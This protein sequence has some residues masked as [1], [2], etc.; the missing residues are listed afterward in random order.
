MQTLG[1]LIFPGFEL[2][3]LFGP[4]EMFRLMK[5]DFDLKLVGI[6]AGAIPSNGQVSAYAGCTIADT[7]DFD[8]ILIP[9]GS[10]TRKIVDDPTLMAW[11]RAASDQ[12]DYVLSVCTGSLLLAAAG[13]QA[14]TNKMAFT[15]IAAQ[16]PQGDWITH[17][18]WVEDSKFITSSGVSAGMDM[19]LGMI[20]KIHG[21]AKAEEV[22]IW[23]EYDW[24]NDKSHDPFADIYGLR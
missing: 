9:G 5:D 1:A 22:A 24:Q 12:A 16:R 19:A 7:P 11:I 8:I 13:K 10:G 6:T 14:T 4:L 15:K 21:Q 23:A 20:A 3:D 18:R 2:L 17:A